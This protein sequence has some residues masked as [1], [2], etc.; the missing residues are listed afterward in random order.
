MTIAATRNRLFFRIPTGLLRFFFFFFAR[1]SV[2]LSVRKMNVQKVNMIIRRRKEKN[3]RF[4]LRAYCVHV[5]A[6]GNVVRMTR[7][8]K[9]YFS[10]ILPHTPARHR[11]NRTSAIVMSA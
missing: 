11:D 5:T 10:H 4:G 2:I 3:F 8:L 7:S 1:S 6:T 9:N